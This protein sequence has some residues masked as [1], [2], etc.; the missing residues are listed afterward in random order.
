[1]TN[2]LTIK[3]IHRIRYEDYELTKS[4]TPQERVERTKA[5]AASGWAQLAE[6]G[7]RIYH[8]KAE[9]FRAQELQQQ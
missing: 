5:A 1:M 2:N 3:D 7:C 4:M 9:L 8:S 6:M